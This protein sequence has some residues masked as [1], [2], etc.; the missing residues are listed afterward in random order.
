MLYIINLKL[1]YPWNFY[2]CTLERSLRTRSTTPFPSSVMSDRSKSFKSLRSNIT[3]HKYWIWNKGFPW[4]VFT[5]A[6]DVSL[7]ICHVIKQILL[8]LWFGRIPDD[9]FMPK[10]G[11]RQDNRISEYFGI[12]QKFQEFKKLYYCLFV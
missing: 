12:K 6:R 10:S 5:R 4:K 3:Y 8:K 2:S 1:T 9:F 7:S 11:I